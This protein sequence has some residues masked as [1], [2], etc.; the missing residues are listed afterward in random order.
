MTVDESLDRKPTIRASVIIPAHNRPD[1]C[2]RAIRSLKVQA[3][4]QRGVE[5]IVVDDGS[6]PPLEASI[7][8]ELDGSCFRIVRN[9]SNRGRGGARN[10]GAGSASGEILIFMDSD[11][12]AHP[13]FVHHY[14]QAHA[15]AAGGA[16]IGH[17][18]WTGTSR[19]HRYLES[20]GVKKLKG[21]QDVPWKYFD[22]SNCSIRKVDLERAGYFPEGIRTWGGEDTSLGFNLHRNGVTLGYL[23]EAVSYH[24]SG[25]DLDRLCQNNYTFGKSS[26]PVMV[27]GE[28]EMAR[29]LRAHFLTAP[30]KDEGWLIRRWIPR[31]LVRGIIRFPGQR[32]VRSLLKVSGERFSYL[33]F[34]YL[35]YSNILRGYQEFLRESGQPRQRGEPLRNDSEL[36]G[37]PGGLARR[38]HDS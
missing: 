12:T 13:D 21:V 24:H 19:L 17:V 26:L 2:V 32:V 37:E 10:A 8:E 22:S 23:R 38:L 36:N 9:P 3:A 15:R 6:V 34:D 25:I 35:V 16:F 20:R 7:G 18:I 14:L 1:D 28:P 27:A 33:C 5:V 30:R 29:E 11:M 31:L 4:A